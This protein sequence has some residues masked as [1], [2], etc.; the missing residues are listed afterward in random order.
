MGQSGEEEKI[1]DIQ[2]SDYTTRLYAQPKLIKGSSALNTNTGRHP[3]LQ[4]TA[5]VVTFTMQVYGA[6]TRLIPI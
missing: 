6:A 5:L 2:I 1:G 3:H 4:Y